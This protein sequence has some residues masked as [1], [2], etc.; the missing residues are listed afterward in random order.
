MYKGNFKITFLH[1]IYRIL[2]ISFF[3]IYIVKKHMY[4]P[5]KEICIKPS[6]DF[7]GKI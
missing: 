6:R 2:I 3:K 5:I 1:L 4:F 7:G